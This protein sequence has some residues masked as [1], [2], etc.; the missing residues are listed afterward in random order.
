MQL[1]DRLRAEVLL[2]ERRNLIDRQ[3]RPNLEPLAHAHV[4]I[5]DGSGEDEPLDS[6]PHRIRLVAR[7]FRE[8]YLDPV[9][10]KHGGD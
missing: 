7:A 9:A 10:R 8:A 3:R 1:H 2:A 4:H 5:E 6:A